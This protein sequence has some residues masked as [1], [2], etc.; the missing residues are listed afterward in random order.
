MNNMPL[1]YVI[2]LNWNGK[3]HLDA[4]FSSLGKL[5]YPHARVVKEL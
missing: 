2:V 5:D 3:E 4:C 1:V